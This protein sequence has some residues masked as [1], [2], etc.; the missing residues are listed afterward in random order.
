MNP[1]NRTAPSLDGSAL[2]H[3]GEVI[4][5]DLDEALECCKRGEIPDGKSELALRRLR[6]RLA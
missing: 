5:V 4:A 3:G 2:E 1:E 6:E